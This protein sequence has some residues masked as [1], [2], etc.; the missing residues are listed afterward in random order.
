V[1][2]LPQVFRALSDDIRL[3][4]LQMLRP[5][6]VCVGDIHAALR[7]P[8]PTASRHLAY[9]RRTGLVA[10][11]RDGLWIYYRLA[12]P[13]DPK[14]ATILDAT[15]DALGSLT[16]RPAAQQPGLSHVSPDFLD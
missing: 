15:L 10:T 2:R 12:S 9:L 4:I 11:R 5:G 8:Q 3:Q 16:V 6:E 7:I 1:D 14:I 13:S